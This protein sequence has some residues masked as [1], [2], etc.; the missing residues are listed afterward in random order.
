MTK[1]A[2]AVRHLAFEDLGLLQPLLIHRGYDVRYLDAGVDSIDLDTLVAADLLV[3]LGGPIGA[4]DA[5]QYPVL[6]EELAALRLRVRADQ[7]TLGICLGAQLLAMALGAS[8][9]P[10]GRT[11]IG[12]APLTLTTAGLASPLRHLDG[13]AVLHWHEDRFTIPEGAAHL[14]VTGRCD[15]QAFCVGPRQLGLQFHLEA[16]HRRID[17]WLIGHAGALAAAGIRPADLRRAA[18][19]H[20]PVL[21]EAAAHVLEEW[22]S[23]AERT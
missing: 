22:L 18:A 1:N 9:A 17:Q 3:V 6:A 20:G 21:A 8:V 19:A 23:G 15:N 12:Y 4:N 11:E 5:D 7:P 16:D 2:L 10:T 13:V 14:A